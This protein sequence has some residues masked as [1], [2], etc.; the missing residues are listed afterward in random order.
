MV[1][2]KLPGKECA[3]IRKQEKYNTAVYCRLSSDDGQT[4]ESCSI[5]TQKTLLTQFCKEY[6]FN[7]Y[8]YY[9]DDGWSGTNFE[10]PDFQRMLGDIEAGKVNMVIVK[11]LSSF[12]REYAQMGLFIEHYFEEN[13]I[14]FLSVSEN[15]DTINGTDNILMPIINVINSLYAKDCS[16]KTKAAHQALAKEGK[17]I[18]GHAPF[19]YLKAP[20]DRHHLI[21][22]PPAADVVR[23]IFQLFCEGVGYVR[24]TKILREKNI[25]N[26]QAYFNQN[27]PDYYKSDYWRKPCDWHATSVRVILSNPIYLG[28]TV[29]GRTENKG[30]YQKKRIAKPQDEWIVV[31]NTHEPIITQE[32]WD[33]VQKLMASKRRETKG[34]EIQMFSGLVKCADCGSSLSASYDGRKGKYKGFSCWVY[35]NYGKQRCT[36]RAIGW[37]TLCTLVLEDIQRNASAASSGQQKYLDALASMKSD[38]QKKEAA[39]LERELKKAEKWI[40]ELDKVISKLYGD[41]ALGKLSDERYA[42]MAQS[43][44]EEQARL[45]TSAAHLSTVINKTNEAFDHAETFTKLISQYPDI[46]ELNTKILNELID[47]I[48]V[49]AQTAAKTS[50]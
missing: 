46:Q 24:L 20:N 3:I 19:G 4:G 30:F 40:A 1:A 27:N 18:G 41:N 50:E 31:D 47:K 44:E 43:Y 16:R 49:H 48:A 37:V 33:T 5:G 13:N 7:V 38:K 36:S 14:R 32:T 9:I 12:G 17:Y 39:K 10:R 11:D 23:L 22:A 28:K 25:L 21:L 34:S 29:F 45:K 2:K 26:P 15:I 8:D 35:K 6:K 42:T